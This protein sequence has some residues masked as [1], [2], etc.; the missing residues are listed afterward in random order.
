MSL[1]DLIVKALESDP[2]VDAE[3]V[4]ENLL[5]RVSKAQ[6]LPLLVDEV[7]SLQRLR[8]RQV[9]RRAFGGKRGAAA[10]SERSRPRLAEVYR[11]TFALYDGRRVSWGEATV[12]DHRQRV[13]RLRMQRRAIGETIARHEDAI[14]LCEEHGVDRLIDIGAAEGAA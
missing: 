7:E 12:A 5:P 1:R 4:A 3:L 11:E 13:D 6:L 8:V 9:E 10:V 2:S 14:S